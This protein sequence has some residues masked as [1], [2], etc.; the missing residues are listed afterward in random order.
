INCMGNVLHGLIGTGLA[1][2]SDDQ[3]AVARRIMITIGCEVVRVALALGICIE[4]IWDIPAQEFADASSQEDIQGLIDQLKA[5]TAPLRISP[6][7]IEHLGVPPRPSLLQDV[8]KG[9]RTEVEYLNGYV[10]KTGAEV[11]VETPM[12]YAIAELMRRQEAGE[13][14][15]SPANLERLQTHL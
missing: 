8:M 4:S 12:N 11:G 2:L 6:E 7:Q 5:N 9:R 15:P 10:A 14:E 3:Q 13:I 1:S